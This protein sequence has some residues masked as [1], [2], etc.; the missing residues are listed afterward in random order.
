MGLLSPLS[1]TIRSSIVLFFMV[2]PRGLL[3]MG[4]SDIVSRIKVG[5]L[6]ELVSDNYQIWF[7]AMGTLLSVADKAVEKLFKT[8]PLTE[9]GKQL[10]VPKVDDSRTIKTPRPGRRS[11]D[12]NSPSP[13]RI[14][15]RGDLGTSDD[16]NGSDAELEQN[17][18]TPQIVTPSPRMQ[19][20]DENS[21]AQF[22]TQFHYESL[23]D[24][25]ERLYFYITQC[26]K[27]VSLKLTLHNKFSQGQP[28]N[29]GLGALWYLATR[30]GSTSGQSQTVI[31]L[32]IPKMRQ[33][34]SKRNETGEA[35][36]ERMAEENV[37]LINPFMES[38]LLNYLMAGLSSNPLKKGVLDKIADG[39]NWDRIVAYI[40]RF[41]TLNAVQEIDNE[42]EIEANAANFQRG[43]GRGGRGGKGGGRAQGGG[44]GNNSTSTCNFCLKPYHQVSTCFLLNRDKRPDHWGQEK[45]SECD[46]RAQEAYSKLTVEQRAAISLPSS[47][48]PNTN[49]EG[50][51]A[52]VD[53]HMAEIDASGFDAFIAETEAVPIEEKKQM[54]TAQNVGHH[55]MSI[56]FLSLQ[57]W[58]ELLKSLCAIL[59]ATFESPS[60]ILYLITI[61]VIC[62]FRLIKILF[63]YL[64]RFGTLLVFLGVLLQMNG[65]KALEMTVEDGAFVAD[66]MSSQ[67][68]SG[69]V[70]ESDMVNCTL[71]QIEVLEQN[72]TMDV[73][74]AEISSNLDTVIHQPTAGMIG[75]DSFAGGDIITDPSMFSS[76]DIKPV[77]IRIRSANGNKTLVTRTGSVVLRF[78]KKGTTKTY[79]VVRRGVAYAPGICKNLLSMATMRTQDNISFSLPGGKGSSSV[80]ILPNGWNMPLRWINNTAYLDPDS[81]SVVKGSGEPNFNSMVAE[82]EKVKPDSANAVSK[83]RLWCDRTC[84]ASAL[85]LSKLSNAT[86]GADC[87]STVPSGYQTLSWNKAAVS[88][89]LT[90]KP[91]VSVQEGKTTRFREKV[92]CDFNIIQNKSYFGHTCVF[93]IIDHHTD[94]AFSYPCKSKS[95]APSKFLQF[96]STTEKYAN[97]KTVVECK[98]DNE[99]VLVD[100]FGRVSRNLSETVSFSSPPYS[101]QQNGRIERYNRTQNE[102]VRYCIAN[103]C[104]PT[105]YWNFAVTHANYVYNRLPSSVRNHTTR[106]QCAT[107]RMPDMSNIHPWGCDI[108]RLKPKETRK[109]KF[110]AVDEKCTYLGFDPLTNTCVVLNWVTGKITCSREVVHYDTLFSFR[111]RK[112]ELQKSALDNLSDNNEEKTVLLSLPAPR[113]LD[114]DDVLPLTSNVPSM[115]SNEVQIGDDDDGE[116]PVDTSHILD[117]NKHI[118][119]H[120]TESDSLKTVSIGDA[121]RGEFP[122][123]HCSTAGCTISSINGVHS[124]AC[125]IDENSSELTKSRSVPDQIIGDRN[126]PRSVR[127]TTRPRVFTA[128]MALWSVLLSATTASGL[129]HGAVH[130]G[131]GVGPVTQLD[132]CAALIDSESDTIMEAMFAGYVQDDEGDIEWQAYAACIDHVSAPVPTF[133]VNSGMPTTLPEMQ[134]H[135]NWATPNG[136]KFAW[137]KEVGRWKKMKALGEAKFTAKHIK[138]NFNQSPLSLATICTI[139]SNDD[140]SFKLCKVR[141]VCAGHRSVQGMQWFENFAS[142]VKWVSNRTCLACAVQQGFK[143][144]RLVDISTAF[145]YFPLEEG[146]RAFCTPIPGLETYDS[147]GSV[148]CPEMYKSVYGLPSAPTQFHK[149]TS[150]VLQEKCHLE[151]CKT[152]PNVYVRHIVI[153]GVNQTIY[154]TTH[155]DDFCVM[156]SH[157]EIY[158]QFFKVIQ[159]EFDCTESPLTSLLGTNLYFDEN[160][161]SCVLH[162][163]KYICGLGKKF[164]IPDKSYRVPA[165]EEMA[166]E[167][168]D[169]EPI[170][171]S[172][173]YLSLR[174][175]ALEY[176][177]LVPSMLYAA[178]C[179][180]PEISYC[181]SRLCSHL[182]NPSEKHLCAAQQCKAYLYHNRLMGIR[183]TRG[184]SLEVK[185]LY[186]RLESNLVSMSDANFSTGRSISGNI[187]FIANGPVSWMAKKQPVTSISTTEAE[188]YAAS[189]CGQD[190]LFLRHLLSDIGLPP[191]T[192]ID[193][194]I[195]CGGI[196][197]T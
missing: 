22:E 164:G 101:H 51:M 154:V 172:S 140:G 93:N 35:F 30:F 127:E 18:P 87:P 98:S 139:K 111:A 57:M 168:W 64:I 69:H 142:M 38:V 39:Y 61:P 92:S 147:D 33:G 170:V 195:S 159:S 80:M 46:R 122:S 167:D 106:Y 162:M 113:K 150:K 53:G 108:S 181:I 16:E 63:P 151:R 137:E 187:S 60:S 146:A 132:V 5:E 104:V 24:V 49:V 189:S 116:N 179:C 76:F 148:L 157:S 166:K 36:A 145:L 10:A 193:V 163:A 153:S 41:E 42:R 34:S 27:L 171:G 114:H 90:A 50:G 66:H 144:F 194:S 173:E 178:T 55:L 143:V 184:S 175:R 15:R 68:L 88:A 120:G 126:A 13:V 100:G 96:L 83:W 190:I 141:I 129:S 11:I 9:E 156:A 37:K 20:G 183:Y 95:D 86:V 75:V 185:T 67:S 169:L 7:F 121:Q 62:S 152:D 12:P 110:D 81:F 28:Y 119:T 177:S 32:N 52:E 79:D 118:S 158:D 45:H 29:N 196:R 197:G 26:C 94:L 115:L 182:D 107:G 188:Y 186:G 133:D 149:G 128:A 191:T 165:S 135:P 19:S 74:D 103:S 97:G 48:S 134:A 99:K 31:S 25:S 4:T 176:R 136:W 192:L 72:C 130:G 59:L 8:S 155:V 117:E 102:M 56:M 138:Q 160:D 112:L 54:T 109:H 70:E 131:V 78:K 174:K 21:L 73:C 58:Q 3:A 89:K 84:G 47:F 1:I 2:A 71:K 85:V 124:G 125:D 82:I 40:N 180:H 14:F 65:V 17:L 123:D 6:P 43:G 23:Q 91:S 105:R 161:G 44:R 77:N